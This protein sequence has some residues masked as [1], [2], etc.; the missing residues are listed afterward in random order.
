MSRE[1]KFNVF[2][3]GEVCFDLDTCARCTTKACVAACNQPN[4]ACVL[5]LENDLPTL[6]VTEEEAARGGCIE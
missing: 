1:F 5:K 6:R 4:L 3:G 2:S